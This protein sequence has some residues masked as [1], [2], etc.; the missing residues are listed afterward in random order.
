VTGKKMGQAQHYDQI[1]QPYERHYFDS[2][3]IQYRH[4]YIYRFLFDGL[5]LNG[6][7]V[8]ELACGSGY[9]TRELLKLFPHADVS[10]ID[11]SPKSV[12]MYMA[13]TGR[14]CLACDLSERG[15]AVPEGADVAFVIGGLHHCTN[16]LVATLE[17]IGRIIRS[18]GLL[19]MA[20]PNAHFFLNAVRNVWYRR[21]RL[22][23]EEEEEPLDHRELLRLANGRFEATSVKYAGGL[24][25]FL[26][27][28]SLVMRIPVKVKGLLAPVLFATED[29]YNCIPGRAPFPMFMARWR[30]IPK[31]D[32]CSVHHADAIGRWQKNIVIDEAALERRGG[33]PDAMAAN[34]T[35]SGKPAGL[36]RSRTLRFCWG[37]ERN[38]MRF[39][40]DRGWHASRI[41]LLQLAK[42]ARCCQ[43]GA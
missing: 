7:R 39:N 10:G 25:Y 27:L 12:E 31:P 9:N 19:I 43:I 20:E 3:S 24:A 30:G 18:D 34:P 6:Q 5:N 21:D 26:I 4:R 36:V 37:A 41:P 14:P 11:I 42:S 35:A 33:E 1:L 16:D 13:N 40:L 2:T 22:F 15:T 38:L 29:V 8:V 28:N 17:N 23:R 32:W